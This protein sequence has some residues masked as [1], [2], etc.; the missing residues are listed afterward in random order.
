MKGQEWRKRKNKQ[1]DSPFIV[2]SL[3][4]SL[5]LYFWKEQ[6]K[7]RQERRSKSQI[8]NKDYRGL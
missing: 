7:L 8:T 1:T 3:F 4:L 5:R 2:Y 6:S